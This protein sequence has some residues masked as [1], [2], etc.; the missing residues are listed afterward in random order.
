[1]SNLIPTAEVISVDGVTFQQ[2][3]DGGGAPI[4]AT[5]LAPESPALSFDTQ[6]AMSYLSRNG[7]PRGL[8]N[9]VILIPS[10]G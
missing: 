10:N 6:N 4:V 8:Q 1:M 2:R 9:T 7:W 5:A 3:F